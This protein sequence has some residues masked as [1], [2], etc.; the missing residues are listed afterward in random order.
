M[1]LD[2][3]LDHCGV[4]ALRGIHRRGAALDVVHLGALVDDDQRSLELPHAL[5]VDPEVG[6]QRELDLH[7]LRHVDERATRPDGRIEGCEL[8]VGGRDDP[9][10]ILAEQVGVLADGG[11]GVGEDDA[12]LRQVFLQRAIHHLA[13]ELR[14]H[15]REELP[16]GLGDAETVEGLLDGIGNFFPGLALLLGGLQ[17]V[18]D[19]LEVDGDVAAPVGH[20]LGVE[21]LER[22]EPEVAHPGRLALHLRDLRDDVRIDA[23]AG[24]E[25][26]R[27]VGAEVVLVDLA[28]GVA[29]ADRDR[30][31][32]DRGLIESGGHGGFLLVSDGGVRR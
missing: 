3:D 24:L 4:E 12:L 19:V 11:V 21:D 14:L 1:L 31:R 25:D 29:R 5:G 32:V 17:V 9:A 15:A 20:R 30:A 18:E 22:L 2:D 28:D 26:G 13:F 23:A 27:R 7:A 10:E 16:F 8:V 6:L